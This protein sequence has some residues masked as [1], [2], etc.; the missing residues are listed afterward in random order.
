MRFYH[1]KDEY[2]AF[3]RQ[4]DQRVALNKQQKRPY[5]GVVVEVD[6]VK[7][8][9][10]LTSPKPKHRRMKNGKDFRKIKQGEY[11]AIN[12]NSMIPVTDS[13]LLSFDI[14][15]IPDEQYRR[16]LQ[17]QYKAVKADRDAI[18]KT[19]EELHTLVLTGDAL[20]STHDREI[21]ARCCDFALLESVCEGYDRQL[22][23]V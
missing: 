2:I 10:P 3:L 17:N 16:L 6:G 18:E 23:A 19:A 21:K 14:E 9:A 13:A 4:Y 22:C 11:G 12:F 20:L 8:Y 15:Q 7:Y 1:I 5:I